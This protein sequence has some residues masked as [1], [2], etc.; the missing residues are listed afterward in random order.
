MENARQPRTLPKFRLPVQLQMLENTHEQQ[1]PLDFIPSHFEMQLEEN[2]K[3]HEISPDTLECLGTLDRGTYGFVYKY[4]HRS[5]QFLMAIKSILVH[6]NSSG[7]PLDMRKRLYMDVVIN[8]KIQLNEANQEYLIR[9]FG[10]LIA[11]NAVW[12]CM[13]LMDTSLKKFYERVYGTGRRLPEEVMASIL[14][15]VVSGLHFLKDR[16]KIMH[17]DIKP[18]NIMMSKDGRVKICDFGISAE[19][20]KH[21]QKAILAISITRRRNVWIPIYLPV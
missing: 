8:Q 5:S 15:S 21:S 14:F 19:L 11:E 17:R 4:R 12:I 1:Y 10:T 2:G 9:S 16:L 3:I 7:D 18:S 6:N 20:E 13:E